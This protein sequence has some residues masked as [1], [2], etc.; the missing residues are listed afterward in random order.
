VVYVA[1]AGPGVAGEG[2]SVLS[3]QLD[4]GRDDV[5]RETVRRALALAAAELAPDGKAWS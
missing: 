4:G 1:L 3:L 2:G 5:R